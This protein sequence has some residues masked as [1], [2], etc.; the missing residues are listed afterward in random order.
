VAQ[1]L[2]QLCLTEDDAVDVGG[3][4]RPDDVRLLAA[5]EDGVLPLEGDLIDGQGLGDNHPAGDGVDDVGRLVEKL[6]LQNAQNVRPPAHQDDLH[7]Q[8]LDRRQRPP[9]IG[10][11]RVVAAHGVYDNF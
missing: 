1:I 5:D 8:L 9:H 4:R 10:G 2:G 7:P 6:P 3:H 11:R